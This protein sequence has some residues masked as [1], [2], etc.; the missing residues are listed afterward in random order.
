MTDSR[1]RLTIRYLGQK[2]YK[3]LKGREVSRFGHGQK[4][5]KN[6]LN[7]IVRGFLSGISKSLFWCSE[8]Q[9]IPNN[10][11]VS[12]EGYPFPLI[13]CAC[14]INNVKERQRNIFVYQYNYLHLD[15]ISGSQVDPQ[16]VWSTQL[17]CIKMGLIA[18]N[19]NTWVVSICTL[20][21][22]II[23][24]TP[25]PFTHMFLRCSSVRPPLFLRYFSAPPSVGEI[26]VMAAP[27][28]LAK[29]GATCKSTALIVHSSLWT[30][31]PTTHKCTS[32]YTHASISIYIPIYIVI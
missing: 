3:H 6:L 30:R 29:H 8:F 17:Q 12:E 20:L 22:M 19:V 5:F 21:D 18:N 9:I 25:L 32:I 7:C 13:A 31:L 23:M 11:S 2:V 27:A 1:L 10:I 26:P 14:V 28:Q 15:I 4:A 16:S 24:L